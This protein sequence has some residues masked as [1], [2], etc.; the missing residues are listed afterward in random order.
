MDQRLFVG[1]LH[2]AIFEGMTDYLAATVQAIAGTSKAEAAEDYDATVF[3]D[4]P[5]E[6]Y[7]ATGLGATA[8]A[9]FTDC[10][11]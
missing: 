1:K 9:E 2:Y 6:C 11:V 10:D 7:E 8:V 4:G 5:S 3:I